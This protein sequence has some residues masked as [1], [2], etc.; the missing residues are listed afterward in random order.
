MQFMIG[1]GAI[2]LNNP[3]VWDRQYDLV[4][5]ESKPPVWTGH[6]E[7]TGQSSGGLA[8]SMR[9]FEA[10]PAGLRLAVE[11]GGSLPVSRL[12]RD[13]FDLEA[14]EAR[15]TIEFEPNQTPSV[16]IQH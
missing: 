1:K 8:E 3:R 13:R 2:L 4:S 6:I 5:G 7:V 11:N 9:W 12:V 10:R 15:F 16:S 14:G